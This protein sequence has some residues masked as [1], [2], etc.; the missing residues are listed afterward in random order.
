MRQVILLI[1]VLTLSACA[2]HP[3]SGGQDRTTFTPSL[4][5]MRQATEYAVTSPM[6]WAPATVA[7]LLQI[8]HTDR[9]IS[10]WLTHHYPIFDSRH[11]TQTAGYATLG[12]S[13]GFYA[14]SV[15]AS[16]SGNRG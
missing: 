13:G 3:G 7:G 1:C 5:R 16:S 6:T 8:H 11:T 2:M 9:P 12:V 10:H 15:L 4:G 14:L